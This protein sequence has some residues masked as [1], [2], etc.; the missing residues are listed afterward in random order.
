MQAIGEVLLPQA[1]L[2]GRRAQAA[3]QV[4]HQQVIDQP[5]TL[6]QEQGQPAAAR[7]RQ[8]QRPVKEPLAAGDVDLQDSACEGGQIVIS[9]EHKRTWLDHNCIVMY[10]C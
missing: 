8:H 4:A 9:D 1:Q 10:I 5:S 2:K 3:A 6:P 7:R